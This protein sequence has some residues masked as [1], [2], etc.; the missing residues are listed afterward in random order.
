MGI[1]V[2]T[3][4][5]DGT[6]LG[7]VLLG[8]S[9]TLTGSVVT[10]PLVTDAS[11]VVTATNIIT[12]AETGTT[13]FLN[14]ATEFV[15]TLPAPAAGLNFKFIVTAAPSGASYTIVTASS[16]NIIIG[17]TV[18][19]ATG[20]ADTEISG[21]DTISFVDGAA[22]VGDRVELDCDGTSWFLFGI[23][24]IATGITITTAS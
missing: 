9:T 23:S 7:T 12:A 24:S 6:I 19:S 16:A 1:Q 5:D 8:S 14:S 21:G 17:S 15:C 13:F 20:A 2:V 18:T 11:E 3:K 4:G 22:K 10:S